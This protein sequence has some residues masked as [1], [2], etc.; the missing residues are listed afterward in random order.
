M[1]EPQQI[2]EALARAEASGEAWILVPVASPPAGEPPYRRALNIKGVALILGVTPSTIVQFRAWTKADRL[3]VGTPPFPA[4][5]VPGVRPPY[6]FP[7]RAGE[8]LDWQAARPGRGVG[9]GAGRHRKGDDKST[10][11]KAATARRPAKPTYRVI[12]DDLRRQIKSARLAPGDR[13]PPVAKL[14]AKHKV[15]STTV[16]QALIYLRGQGL[17]ESR[18]G[19]GNYVAVPPPDKE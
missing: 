15:S 16:Q 11:A 19:R 5:E 6:W 10:P 18:R 8:F 7:E 1:A 3:P 13:V 17:I 12:A 14:A 9:G 2:Q 4:E